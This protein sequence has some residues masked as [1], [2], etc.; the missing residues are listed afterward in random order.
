M[1]KRLEENKT[2]IYEIDG[3]ETLGS[4]LRITPCSDNAPDFSRSSVQWHR[5]SPEGGKKEI[6]SG[7]LHF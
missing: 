5:V 7:S 3:S 6:I 1:K 4:C 2:R